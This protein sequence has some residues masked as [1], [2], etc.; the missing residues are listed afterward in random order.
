LGNVCAH[1]PGVTVKLA[2]HTCPSPSPVTSPSNGPQATPV[3]RRARDKGVA[4]PEIY[5]EYSKLTVRAKGL[6]GANALP[7][8]TRAAGG[9]LQK[10]VLPSTQKLKEFNVLDGVS[11]MLMR[12]CASRQSRRAEVAYACALRRRE[13]ASEHT[14]PPYIP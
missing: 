9:A 2:A 11:G 6:V 7:T 8:L 14:Q 4:F 5:V 10:A 12:T 3:R 1:V 13:G